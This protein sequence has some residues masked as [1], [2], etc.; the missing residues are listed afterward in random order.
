LRDDDALAEQHR[1]LQGTAH[2]SGRRG[3]PAADS[4]GV[5]IVEALSALGLK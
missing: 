2:G 4:D 5:V 1:A 3:G